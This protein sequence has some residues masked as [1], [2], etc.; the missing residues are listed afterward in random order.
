MAFE[1][2]VT[3]TLVVAGDADQSPLTVRGPDWFAD[4]YRLS[5]GGRALLT[6]YGGEHMLGGISGYEAAETTDEDSARVALVQ[7]VSL[8]FLRSALDPMITPGRH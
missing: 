2:L 3:P 8:G 5:P 7:E 4:P 1:H 6:L